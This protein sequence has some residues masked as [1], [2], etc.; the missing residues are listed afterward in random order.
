V[1][2]R[3]AYVNL[4]AKAKRRELGDLDPDQRYEWHHYF[5]VCFWRD[6]SV[7]TKTVPLT[8]REHWIA[9][10]LLFKM[11]PRP[12]TATALLCMGKRTPKMNSRKFEALRLSLHR[13]NWTQTQEGRKYF[14]DLM[15]ERWDSGEWDTDAVRQRCREMGRK[16]QVKWKEEGGHPLSSEAAR[17][18]SSERAKARNKEMNARLNKEKGKVARICDKC[19][20][21]IRGTMGNMKQH[22][23]GS[24]CHTA[25]EA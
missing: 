8:L 15:K 11:F 16:I 25:N 6:R 10:K 9:H 14:S 13:H 23:R 19:G 22:Q 20:A 3:Q 1:N 4:I 7:N 5:P 17:Q 18:S 12:G 2:Y 21:Q 24:K